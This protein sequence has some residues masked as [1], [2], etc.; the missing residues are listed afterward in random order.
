MSH[1]A[2]Y[3]GAAVNG[4][5]CPCLKGTLFREFCGMLY[6]LLLVAWGMQQGSVEHEGSATLRVKPRTGSACISGKGPTVRH[7][8]EW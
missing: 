3:V 8:A 1:V 5:P 2:T 7:P 6:A 4:G